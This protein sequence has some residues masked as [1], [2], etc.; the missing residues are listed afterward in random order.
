MC[1]KPVPDGATSCPDDGS[2]F[3]IDGADAPRTLAYGSGSPM[4]RASMTQLLG[5]RLGDYEV[6]ELIGEGGMGVVYRGVQPVIKKRVAIKVLRPE[7]A[8]DQG[9]VKRLFAEAEAVNSIGH[10]NIIDIFNVGV[11]PDGRHYIVME[12][13]DGEPLDLFMRRK[14]PMPAHEVLELLGEICVPL[15]AAHQ[16][17]VIHRDLKPSNIFLCEQ[18]GGSRYVKLLDFG[19]AKMGAVGGRVSQ[20]S[21]HQIAGTPDYMAPE[22]ARAL[23]VSVQTDLYALGVIAFQM[24]TGRLPFLGNTPMDVM[25]QHVSAPCPTPST[26]ERTV[27]GEV[28]AFVLWLMAKKPEDRPRSAEDVRF[29]LKRL[30]ALLAEAN[31]QTRAAVLKRTGPLPTQSA[32]PD[33]ITPHDLTPAEPAL[34][35]A[36]SQPTPREGLSAKAGPVPNPGPPPNATELVHMPG[37][38]RDETM[39]SDPAEGTP[40]GGR[41]PRR[42]GPIPGDTDEVEPT[43]GNDGYPTTRLPGETLDAAP[44]RWWQWVALAAL[45][46]GGLGV[47][48]LLGAKPTGK[49]RASVPPPELPRPSLPSPKEPEPRVT[50]TATPAPVAQPPVAVP[51]PT[52]P[53][54][55]TP[56]A[57]A[58]LEP[59]P[60]PPRVIKTAAADPYAMTVL[61]R[62]LDDLEHSA[63]GDPSKQV[64][65]SSPRLKLSKANTLAERKDV[66][67]ELDVLEPAFLKR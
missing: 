1:G 55:A 31:T 28:D 4:S 30:D 8:T 21:V 63:A 61:R 54:P 34:G 67:R 36:A 13:L 47:G 49:P 44:S 23:D 56:T 11:L 3:F 58:P 66:A 52:R 46:G 25:V 65:L 50:A 5:T 19:L 29:E 24:L 15:H 10:R 64:L 14:S 43:S 57:T 53:A 39:D 41:D 33:F 26:V 18:A 45:L 12:Y 37:D 42:R 32:S 17:G 59:T 62:R 60:K 22:Q 40:T 48:W 20:T 38:S 9:Q 7:F 16:A 2:T 27:P 6:L 51:A 35:L